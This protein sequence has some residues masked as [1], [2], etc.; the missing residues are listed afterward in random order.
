M[1]DVTWVEL[2]AFQKEFSMFKLED[3]LI[4]R[5]GGGDEMS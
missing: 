4:V 2:E 5:G 1:A 3:E